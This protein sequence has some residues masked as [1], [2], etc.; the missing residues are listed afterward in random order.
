MYSIYLQSAVKASKIRNIVFTEAEAPKQRPDKAS[1]NPC[2][3]AGL[4]KA[5]RKNNCPQSPKI[6]R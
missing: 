6:I 1:H 2:R 3:F 4:S 5:M